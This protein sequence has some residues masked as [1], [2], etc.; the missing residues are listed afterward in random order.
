MTFSFVYLDLNG[1]S[2]HSHQPSKSHAGY[3]QKLVEC[4]L[5]PHYQAKNCDLLFRADMEEYS[6]RYSYIPQLKVIQVD[7]LLWLPEGS[8]GP[9]HKQLR[10][11]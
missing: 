2:A 9:S 5:P 6:C 1:C 11:D 10:T 4:Y 3:R 7:F 8:C